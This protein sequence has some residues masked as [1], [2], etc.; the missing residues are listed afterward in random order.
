MPQENQLVDYVDAPNP[1][2]CLME[3]DSLITSIGVNADRL[4]NASVESEVVLIIQVE[5]VY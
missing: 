2:Y 3:S 4:L 5:V 1:L